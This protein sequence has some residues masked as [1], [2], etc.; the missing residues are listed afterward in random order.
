MTLAAIVLT[1]NEAHHIARCLASLDGVADTVL[2]VDSHSTDETAGIAR[3][4]GATVVRHPFVNHAA[5]FNWALTQ[6]PPGTDWVLRIDADEYLTP[7]LAREIRT[8]LPGLGPDVAGA[9]CCRRIAFEGRLLR[10][11]G[12][13]PVRVLRLF[14]FGRGRCEARWM[15]EHITVDGGTVA[16]DGALVDD[17]LNSLTWWTAKHN[18]YASR[19]AVELLNL[20]HGFMARGD[21][22]EINAGAQARLKRRVKE[23]VYAHLP[24]GLRAL[25]YFLYR[26][27]LRLGFL[28]GAAG[29]RFHIL[30]GF[31]YRYLV[32]AKVA[33]VKRHMAQTGCG[34]VEAIRDRLEIDI[35]A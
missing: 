24:G 13:H 6:L 27:V 14:R 5:Q 2:V 35:G 9:T 30:Q 17:N 23:R 18:A 28:D 4:L 11:G 33:E 32:D 15:D 1:L 10:H 20:D 8:R 29:A 3:S 31:W 34:P 7:E 16:L 25:A 12:L 19:E 21:R 26:Y 22:A